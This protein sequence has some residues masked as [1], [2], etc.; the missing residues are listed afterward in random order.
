MNKKLMLPKAKDLHK[1][2]FGG[3]LAECYDSLQNIL[4]CVADMNRPSWRTDDPYN[5]GQAVTLLEM[6]DYSFH[7]CHKDDSTWY[8]LN[9]LTSLRSDMHYFEV[10]PINSVTDR[11]G[12]E[13][14]RYDALMELLGKSK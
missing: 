3:N 14:G 13:Q 4:A 1:L 5:A 11:I 6:S 12:F 8:Q 7:L 9:I 2:S 10:D